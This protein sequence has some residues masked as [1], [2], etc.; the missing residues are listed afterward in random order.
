MRRLEKRH[1]NVPQ[2]RTEPAASSGEQDAN[3]IGGT[4]AMKLKEIGYWVTTAAIALETRAGWGNGPDPWGT[5]PGGWPASCPDRDARGLPGVPAHH[6]G[7]VETA[8]R[9][10]L[11]GPTV[12]SAEANGRMPVSSSN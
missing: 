3:D 10:D 2:E 8:W 1:E 11:A 12:S 7:R 6:P 4:V 5:R 9:H